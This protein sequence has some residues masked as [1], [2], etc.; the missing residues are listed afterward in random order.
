MPEED[1]I[2][3]TT[4]F[5]AALEAE[6]AGLKKNRDETKERYKELQ[7][8]LKAFDGIDPDEYQKLQDAREAAEAEKAK[9][10]GD[11]EKLQA[12]HDKKLAEKD[13]I[14][15][16]QDTRFRDTR[17][18]AEAALAIAKHDGNPT[19]L[20]NNV[21]VVLE[22]DDDYN[23]FT[24]VDGERVSV[25]DYVGGLKGTDEWS[26]AFAPAGI[27]GSGSHTSETPGGDDLIPK[28][29]EFIGG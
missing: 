20:L 17:K 4:E 28:G 10:A 18:K 29:I 7:Q 3:Q 14:I 9:A 13:S 12:K 16:D 24:T 21:L 22:T 19:L 25:D 5:K 1:D 6:V 26:G 27:S 8:R 23:V 2:T 11:W 15:A